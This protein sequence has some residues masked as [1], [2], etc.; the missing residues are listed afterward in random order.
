AMDLV[1]RKLSID[2]GKHWRALHDEISNFTEKL[3]ETIE[4]AVIKKNLSKITA[5]S[6]E[7]AEWLLSQHNE[8]ITNTMAGSVP[9]LRMLSTA[10]GCYLMAKGALS[11]R[12]RLDNGDSDK[13]F[14]EGKIITSRYYAEQIVPTVLGLAEA[15]KAGDELFYAIDKNNFA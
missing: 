15:I 5:M 3:P 7:C 11:A 12:N 9:Y 1:G 4:F 10:V 14:L 13:E 6:K 8:S 2:N